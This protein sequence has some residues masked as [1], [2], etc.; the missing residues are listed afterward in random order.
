MPG[1]PSGLLH[2]SPVRF[3]FDGRGVGFDRV[4]QER[5]ARRGREGRLGFRRRRDSALQPTVLREVRI[6]VSFSSRWIGFCIFGEVPEVISFPREGPQ[7][8]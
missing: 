1:V 3:G 6:Q 5:D 8:F 4:C 2:G 7:T